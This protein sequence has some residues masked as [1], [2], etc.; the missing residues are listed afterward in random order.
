MEP[1]ADWVTVMRNA[2]EALG[3]FAG[4][5]CSS[6]T[7]DRVRHMWMVQQLN[8][9]G[10]AAVSVPLEIRRDMPD[11]PWDRLSGLADE[12]AGVPSMSDEDMQL[13]VERVVPVVRKALK[14]VS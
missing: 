2:G 12:R 14:R 10:K 5:G 13:F 6:M 1:V 11:V 9:L 8:V 3:R 7:C 4:R